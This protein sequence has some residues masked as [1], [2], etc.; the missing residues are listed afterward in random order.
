MS[1][2]VNATRGNAIPQPP[3]GGGPFTPSP[4]GGLL[5]I[6]ARITDSAALLAGLAELSEGNDTC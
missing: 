2:N 1:N 4:M 6:V 5:P 3:E